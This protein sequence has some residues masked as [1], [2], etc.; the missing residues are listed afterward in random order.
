MDPLN[1]YNNTIWKEFIP[2]PLEAIS[3]SQIG[4]EGKARADD[5][6]QHTREYV[7]ILKR[8]STQPSGARW[9][10]VMA[11]NPPLGQNHAVKYFLQ[12]YEAP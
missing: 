11:S 5:K 10:F 3:K 12:H 1:D 9:G 6:A 8:P 4:F 2:D 7:S